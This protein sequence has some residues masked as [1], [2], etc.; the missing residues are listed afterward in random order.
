MRRIG[1]LSDT[2]SFLDPKVFT[3][4]E[5]C[6]EIWHAGDFGEIQVA[7][8]LLQFRPLKGVYGNIDGPEIKALFPLNQ[9]FEIEGFKVRIIH[10]GGYPGHYPKLL[11]E[12]LKQDP[13]TLFICGH[14]HILRVIQDPD[15]GM[16]TINPGAAGKHGFHHIRTIMKF[17]LSEGKIDAM[18][19]IELG[20]RA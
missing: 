20:K 11:K 2:H 17:D 3:H 18:K 1:L 6:H 4:F 14:S 5:D 16:L 12:S 7:E 10:I 15:L 19:V 13:C 8:S 9:N